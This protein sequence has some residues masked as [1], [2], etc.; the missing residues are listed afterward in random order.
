VE[1]LVEE[2]YL[3]KKNSE[4]GGWKMERP[5][6]DIVHMGLD[7]NIHITINQTK[8]ANKQHDAVFIRMLESKDRTLGPLA[9]LIHGLTVIARD[10][11]DIDEVIKQIICD[12]MYILSPMCRSCK[13]LQFIGIGL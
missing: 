6:D 8:L 2:E 3:F 4:M 13:I 5:E 9:E 7:H 12:I 10:K 11:W 1:Q